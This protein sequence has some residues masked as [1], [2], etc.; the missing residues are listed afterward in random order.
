MDFSI[1]NLHGFIRNK[2]VNIYAIFHFAG[3]KDG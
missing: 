3:L 1:N 2:L